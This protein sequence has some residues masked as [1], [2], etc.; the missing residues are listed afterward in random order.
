MEIKN[1]PDNVIS[2]TL[3]SSEPQIA[4]ELK[5]LNKI[6]Q[7]NYIIEASVAGSGLK[8]RLIRV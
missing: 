7:Y 2:V 8:A 4:D 5:E 1:L 3:S 6:P